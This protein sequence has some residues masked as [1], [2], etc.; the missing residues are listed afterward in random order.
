M[1]RLRLT[2]PSVPNRAAAVID[3][4]FQLLVSL[5]IAYVSDPYKC[6]ALLNKGQW[7]D[8]GPRWSSR[9]PF[10]NWQ[11]PGCMMYEYK[12][13]DIQE[14]FQERRLVFIGDS[15]TR[16]IFWAVAKKMDQE[17][18]EEK[19]TEHLDL[20]EKHKDLEF[21]SS[22]VT[23]RFIWDPYLNSTGLDRELKSFNANPA[24]DSKKDESAALILLGSPG[25]WYARHGQENFFKDFRDSIEHVIPFMDHVGGEHALKEA[26]SN[27]FP[28]KRKSPNFLLLAPVQVPW[29]QALSPSREETITPEK[30]DQMNDYL[31][32]VSA[33]SEADIVWS[34]SLMTWAGRGEYEES[35]LHVV[36][37][38]AHRKADVLLN[39]RCNADAVERGYP[40]ERTC[41]NN[42][43]QPNTIQ[44]LFLLVGMILLPIILLLRRK[45]ILR[46]GRVLPQPE[47]LGALMT[48]ALVVCYCYYADR[49][50][51]FEKEHKQFRRREFLIASLVVL[52]AGLISIRTNNLSSPLK[53]L[54]EVGG[55]HSFDHGFLSRNQTDEWKG[56]MQFLIL[57]YHYTHGSKTLWLFE[58]MRN[59]V[60]GY[61]FM[62]GY[63][64]T[65]YFLKREDYS[66]KRVAGVLIRLNL[67]TCALAYMMRTDYMAH[68][69]VPLV[70][71][72]FLV[73]YFTLKIK[74]EDNSN[75]GFLLGKIFI[76]AILTTAF[77][78]IPGILEILGF[79]LKYSCAISWNIKEWRYRSSMDMFIVYIGM[80]IA[81]LY[82]RLTRI[83]SASISCT[84][85]IDIL[86]RPIARHP[87]LFQ[88]IST[89]TSLIL[90]PGFHLI[91]QIF[92]KKQDYLQ[93]HPYLS[94]M[95]ILAFISLRNSHG[96]LRNHHSTIWAWLG[97]CSLETFILQN[98]IWMAAD[99]KGILRLG[100]AGRWVEGAALTLVF[101]GVSWKVEGCT[102]RITEWLVSGGVDGCGSGS[103]SGGLDMGMGM[104]KLK[105]GILPMVH[106]GEGGGE[107]MGMGMGTSTP[108]KNLR[109][110][111][112]LGNDGSRHGSSNLNATG[113]RRWRHKI[114]RGMRDDLRWRVAGL[115][116]AMWV[117][118]WV[119]T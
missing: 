98:H 111:D 7:L 48:F 35:G 94:W 59:L 78:K 106:D 115:L 31:Q 52:I 22:G 8:P 38:V 64:H 119:Y 80:I 57:I 70:S 87:A 113:V 65:M 19:I 60:A 58:I 101:A 88:T 44:W 39:L 49:T 53:G 17:R 42:Y 118:N 10:Q 114:V 96:L 51:L 36:D 86:L 61:L 102:A 76:S 67:L 117:G 63:G 75:T 56:W 5:I 12:Q 45:H 95:P 27:P 92:T 40:Y 54:H 4:G 69:F 2:I 29:Y 97:R 91:T 81:I 84:S 116:V 32:Q 25:L 89:A 20:E 82:L 9:N 72:W 103:G 43:R 77:I 46:V 66:F 24:Q 33:H 1:S 73:V 62:T 41:C 6:G 74:Q 93:W 100:V 109:F 68:Y 37:N 110:G 83:K 50:Q 105:V 47:V 99:L 13:K 85:K 16:Q 11:P 104:E 23:V 107:G 34:F 15:T 71:F 21:S 90:L 112:G 55:A 18:A 30:I 26:T 79:I 14:C 28:L 108:S 3:K